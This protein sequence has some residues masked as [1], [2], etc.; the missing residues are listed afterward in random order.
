MTPKVPPQK[1][2]DLYNEM[3]ANMVRAETLLWKVL[4][5]PT[6]TDAQVTEA[7]RSYRA[8]HSGH[9]E[10]GDSLRKHFPQSKDLYTDWGYKGL[11]P[12]NKEGS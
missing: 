4:R 5:H 12:W 7:V 8:S 3:C 9:R 2:I 10:V 11:Y 1:V 6:A